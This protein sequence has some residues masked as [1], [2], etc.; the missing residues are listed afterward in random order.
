MRNPF[1]QAIYKY[2]TDFNLNESKGFTNGLKQQRCKIN[3]DYKSRNIKAATKKHN[4]LSRQ[5]CMFHA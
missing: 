3:I 5:T 2:K 4:G 1:R